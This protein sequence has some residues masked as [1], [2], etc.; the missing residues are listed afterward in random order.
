MHPAARQRAHQLGCRAFDKLHSPPPT[1][2]S[3][4][5]PAGQLADM[6]RNTLKQRL[7]SRAP[8]VSAGAYEIVS[9]LMGLR[10][11]GEFVRQRAGTRGD[12]Q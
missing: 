12:V 5:R 3:L 1:I 6:P 4:Q 2:E 10:D 8:R 9:L 11:V 7:A